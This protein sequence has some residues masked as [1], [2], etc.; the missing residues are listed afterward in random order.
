MNNSE[1]EEH[2]SRSASVNDNQEGTAQ[3]TV[4]RYLNERSTANFGKPP[5]RCGLTAQAKAE[6]NNIKHL[7][8][9]FVKFL[10]QTAT[11]LTAPQFSF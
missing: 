6:L 9:K 1:L 4:K 5:S 10:L 3:T 2:T 7:S 8:S 11:Y